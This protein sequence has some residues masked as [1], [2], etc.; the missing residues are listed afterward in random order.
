MYAL[1]LCLVKQFVIELEYIMASACV[2][3]PLLCHFWARTTSSARDLA[4]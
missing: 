1:N 3:D 2:L 4:Y